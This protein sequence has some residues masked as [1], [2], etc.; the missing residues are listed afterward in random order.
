MAYCP[1]CKRNHNVGFISTR[2]AG[3]D[4]VSLETAKWADVFEKVGFS[5]YY[6]AGELDRP[7][8]CSFLIEEAHFQHPDIKDVFRNCF[9][10]RVR[11]RFVTQKIYELKRKLKDDIYRFIEK[12]DIDLLV[13]ENALTIPLNLPLGIAIT[14]VISETG[15]PTIAHHHDFF[16][17]RQHFMINAAWEYLNM[18]FPPH[19]PTIQH[20]VINSSASNQ[21][22]LRT[23]ISATI[24]PNVMDFENPPTMVRGFESCGLDTEN[25]VASTD[26]YASDVRQALGVADDE[27]L[28]LQPTRVVKRKG[29][30]HA[31]ELVHRLDMKAKL[32][33]SHASGDEGY[34]YERRVREY[35]K[36]LKV[37]TYFVSNIINEQR[38][39]TKN[40]RKIYTLED[41]YPH[42]DLITY[43]STFEGFGNAFLEA[44]YFCRPIVVNTYSIYTMDI[45]PKGFSVIE[46]D[47]Y[48]SDEAVRK[49]RKVLADTEF[50][51]KMVKH[52]YETAKHYYSY[53]VL[54]NKLKTLIKDCTGCPLE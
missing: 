46:I 28:I 17:E 44:I 18:A 1:N 40:G 11:G 50:R 38:G 25:K 27:V 41:V 8:E 10:A 32:V 22:S 54:H 26:D 49:T 48:V 33:I 37:D 2:F 7:P 30:E 3:T 51:S 52:N 43:P 34:D 15:M 16:W 13:P 53:S 12:F 9:G 47:G 21:L 35:S 6:F 20:V 39:L 31:I 4:G 5:S 29:I 45:K 23:G 42:A 36:L 14:E 24:I 19:L